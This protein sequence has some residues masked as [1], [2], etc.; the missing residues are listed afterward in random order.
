M[1]AKLW[2][3]VRS[4]QS[5]YHLMHNKKRM[6]YMIFRNR[7][8]RALCFFPLCTLSTSWVSTSSYT[9]FSFQ[10]ISCHYHNHLLCMFCKDWVRIWQWHTS[11]FEWC[12]CGTG[13]SLTMSTAKTIPEVDYICK[14]IRATDSKSKSNMTYDAMLHTSEYTSVSR[15]GWPH[16]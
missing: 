7:K 2:I 4:G 13:Q 14:S 5:L 9:E 11:H 10:F 12:H 16:E 15:I 6:K 3:S 1:P 8:N